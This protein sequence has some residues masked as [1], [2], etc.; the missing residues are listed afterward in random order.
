[1]NSSMFYSKVS[2]DKYLIRLVKGE[3]VGDS[4]LKFCNELDIKNAYLTAIGAIESPTVAYYDVRVKKFLEKNL[5][6]D[7]ELASFIGNIAIFKNKPLLH[8]H[9]SLSDSEMKVFGGH[10]VSAKV[11]ASV[12]IVLDIFETNH[13]KSRDEEVGL[14]LWNLPKECK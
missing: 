9:V 5:S 12:E 14:N 6:G 11:A 10:F 13:I 2:K 4:I 1:M 7:Y 3:N 8:A